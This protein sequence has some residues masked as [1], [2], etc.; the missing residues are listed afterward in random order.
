[1][2]VFRFSSALFVLTVATVLAQSL[3][4]REWNLSRKNR[5]VTTNNNTCPRQKLTQ[6]YSP[7]GAILKSRESRKNIFHAGEKA[8]F[9]CKDDYRQIGELQ[10]FICEEHGTW[11]EYSKHQTGRSFF[12]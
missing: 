11:K 5:A 10:S 9:V 3:E 4:N 1:M 7:V 6:P 2:N 8:E 12:V